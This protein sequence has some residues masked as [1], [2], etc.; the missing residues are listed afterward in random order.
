MKNKFL[1]VA[2][3]VAVMAGLAVASQ[4]ADVVR[5]TGGATTLITSGVGEAY[6][7]ITNNT[8]CTF[9]N[10]I[11]DCRDATYVCLQLKAALHTSGTTANS[12]TL[13]GSADMVNW[14]ATTPL[15]CPTIAWTPAGA[16]AVV[17]T[18]N[19]PVKGLPYIRIATIA[20]ANGNTDSHLTNYT[21]KYFTK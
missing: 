16:T 11:I 17:T 6:A 1:K 7:A 13:Q 12:F 9:T 18:T 19:I 8:S 3:A 14:T 10:A 21:V 5:V 20:N 15:D 2:G 4:A